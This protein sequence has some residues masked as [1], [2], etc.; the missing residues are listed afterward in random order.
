MARRGT[1]APSGKSDRKNQLVLIVDDNEAELFRITALLEKFSY[2][3]LKATND[4]Q[5][6]ANAIGVVPSLAIISLDL[7][8]MNDLKLIWQ[9]KNHPATAHIPVIGIAG[10]DDQDLKGYCLDLGAAGFLCRPFEAEELYKTVQT[11]LEKNPRSGMRVNTVLPVKVYGGD[12]DALYGAYALTLSSGGMFLRT[13]NPVTV[14][15]GISLE[16]NLNGRAIAAETT[17]LYNCQ[18]GCGPEMETG[19]G[20][21]FVDI[22]RKDR[23]VVSEFIRG[24]VMKDVV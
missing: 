11:A 20:L 4:E 7:P 16:F 21:R 10:N 2:Q 24:E 23:E 17:V 12:Y 5:A 8:G 18:N 19:V 9:L 1:K 22:S 6:F 15:S 13:M 14:H 3:T